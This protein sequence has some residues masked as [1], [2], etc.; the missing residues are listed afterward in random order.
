MK[1]KKRFNFYFDL[2]GHS[3]K[4]N[5]FMYGPECSIQHV[6]YELCRELPRLLSNITSLFRYYSCIF[7]IT[8]EKST[9]SRAILNKILD[10]PY[11]YT[12][13]SSNGFY[14]DSISHS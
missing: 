1:H 13:E 9:T 14:F 2:H 7:R 3:V 8:N 11:A 5:V 4:K 12:M 10:I 6:N